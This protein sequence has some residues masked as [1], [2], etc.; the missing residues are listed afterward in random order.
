VALQLEPDG[1]GSG[2]AL[3]HTSFMCC[4][5]LYVVCGQ[6]GSTLIECVVVP[7]V[8]QLG[9]STTA[10]Q[11]GVYGTKNVEVILVQPSI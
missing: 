3:A 4:Y 2:E 11:N 10:N 6:L 9:G 5:L 1:V 8:A 7:C